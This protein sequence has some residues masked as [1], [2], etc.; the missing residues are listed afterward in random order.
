MQR[1]LTKALL[2]AIKPITTGFSVAS[3]AAGR[4]AVWSHRP[5]HQCC[6]KFHGNCRPRFQYLKDGMKVQN[7]FM[8]FKLRM[9]ALQRNSFRRFQSTH[10]SSQSKNPEH[11]TSFSG[12][13]AWLS[14][15]YK[16]LDFG[17]LIMNLGAISGLL[18]FMMSDVLH[19]RM[20]SIM[21][22]ACGITYNITR[23]PRQINACL[24]GAVFISTN[25]Y[26][27]VQLIRERNQEGPQFSIQEL[28]L[29][30]RHFSDHGVDHQTF[31]RLMDHATWEV[32][33]AGDVIV[34]AG[35]PLR[36][37]ILIHDGVATAFREGIDR[38]GLKWREKMY[39]YEGRGRNG[40]IIGG[41]ALVEPKTTRHNYPQT[42]RSSGGAR[43]EDGSSSTRG[44]EETSDGS[45]CMRPST[46]NSM[47]AKESNTTIV[48]SWDREKLKELLKNDTT[49]EA[50][51]VH[52]LYVDLLSG[53]RRQRTYNKSNSQAKIHESDSQLGPSNVDKKDLDPAAE[54]LM[55]NKLR[56]QGLLMKYK[57]MLLDCI[58]EDGI[59]LVPHKKREARLFARREGI[60]ASQHET[61]IASLGWTHEEWSD[62]IRAKD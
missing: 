37:V 38:H 14:K 49:L 22:S 3:T 59:K 31:Q 46:P 25:M 35:K 19:L 27:I 24:W 55:Q 30:Q 29:W 50:A 4:I 42:V 43:N 33:R 60:S 5:L 11:S 53:L 40:C 45:A 48:V 21:G 26:M 47:K 32:K 9:D 58:E 8:P 28:E 36:R 39:E 56:I 57:D 16:R 6:R 18:G 61:T 17:T 54:S 62:G 15:I 34:P 44:K 51:F 23:A 13:R 1:S 12:F 10:T 41:T 7:N 20:L 2:P 52:T